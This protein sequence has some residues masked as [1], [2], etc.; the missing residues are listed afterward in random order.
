[1]GLVATPNIFVPGTTA[2]AT[3]VNA[4]VAAIVFE[5]NGNI[6]GDNVDST[7]GPVPIGT[8]NLTGISQSIALADHEHIV[9]GFEQLTAD[10]STG[11]KVGRKYFNT[12]TLEERMCIDATGSGTWVTSGNPTATELVVH[13][14]QHMDGAHDP[15]PDN[16]LTDHMFA[17]RTITSASMSGDVSMPADTWVTLCSVDVTTIGL[18]TLDVKLHV[19][20]SNGNGTNKPGVMLRVTD[21]TAA[22]V[23]IYRSP[24]KH[25][26]GQ[27]GG[28]ADAAN[29]EPGFDY[30]V[31]VT[32][33]RTLRVQAIADAAGCTAQKPITLET[34]NYLVPQ[35]TV[36]VK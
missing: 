8:R 1:M 15:L 17:A 23:T 10:P 16:I 6:N 33:L 32:G 12:V 18:Q 14:A 27:S 4:D 9:Q 31:P 29:M 35:I 2:D 30:T 28:Q 22:D 24:G 20:I 7:Q 11:N 3:Q 19:K 5:L 34:D 13:A 26:L 36:T 25:Q 21:H